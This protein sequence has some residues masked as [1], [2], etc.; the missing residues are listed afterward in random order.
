MHIIAYPHRFVNQNRQVDLPQE[1]YFKV[2]I[3]G[4]EQALSAAVRLFALQKLLYSAVTSAIILALSL[5][6]FWNDRRSAVV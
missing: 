3:S 6:L 2:K 5:K 1:N 4:K